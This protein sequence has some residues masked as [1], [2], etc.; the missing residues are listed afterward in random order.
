MNEMSIILKESDRYKQSRLSND[1]NNWKISEWI[2]KNHIHGQKYTPQH[3]I[4]AVHVMPRGVLHI[5]VIQFYIMYRVVPTLQDVRLRTQ[6]CLPV[7]HC[8]LV[9]R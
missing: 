7:P 1:S 9:Q 4:L 2:K 3:H 6:L 5:S 8:H